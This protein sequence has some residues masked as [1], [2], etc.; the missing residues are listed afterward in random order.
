L[1][2][3]GVDEKGPQLFHADPSGTL[4]KYSAK[5]IGSG[6]EGAQTELQESYHSSLTLAEAIKLSL[7]ILK[8][9][10]EE[11]I[12]ASNVQVATVTVKDGF[13]MEDEHALEPV[14]RSLA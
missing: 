9:V 5:A 4:T 7:K 13:K 3:G 10:M 12:S 11:K 1:L 8:S 2:I 14:I 6:S